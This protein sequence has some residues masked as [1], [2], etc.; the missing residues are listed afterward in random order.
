MEDPRPPAV[1]CLQAS[2]P[3]FTVLRVLLTLET[4][5]LRHPLRGENTATP[6]AQEAGQA[7]RS[8][9]VMVMV[10]VPRSRR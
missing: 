3:D 9:R 5:V 8:V 1:H 7:I 4:H 6:L 2:Q 10:V